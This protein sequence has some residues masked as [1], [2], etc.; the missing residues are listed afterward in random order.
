MCHVQTTYHIWFDVSPESQAEQLPVVHE[1]HYL[2]ITVDNMAEGQV[3]QVLEKEVTCSLCLDLFKDPKKLPCDHVYCKECLRGLALRSLNATISCPE[4]RT[5][6]QIPGNDVINFPTAFRVNRLIEAFQQVQVRVETDSPNTSGICHTH[7][8][9]PLALYCET[10][11]KQVCRDCVLMTKEHADHKYDFFKEVAPKYREKLVSEVSLVKTQDSSISSALGEIIAAE[12]SITNNVQKCQDDVEH[13]FEEMTSILQACKRAMK[14]EATAYYSSLTGVFDQQ[15][16]RLK[17]IQS[18]IKSV[19]T[20]VDTTLRDDDQSFLERMESTFERINN[21]QRKFQTVSLTVAKP[22]LIAMQSTESD[23]DS[24]KQFIKTKYFFG[25]VVDAKMCLVDF[26]NAKLH[27]GQQ[28]SFTLTLR[29]SSGNVC[30]R[31]NEVN[32]DLLPRQGNLI[33]GKLV[34]LSQG[35]VKVILTPERRGQQ[36]LNV[37]VNGAHIKNSPFNVTVYMPPQFFSRPVATISGL[38]RPS[39]LVY[40]QVEDKVLATEMNKERVIKIDSQSHLVLSEF[41]KL[42][43]VNEITQDADLNTFYATT[44][45]DQLHK[46]S[47]NGRI[48]K[49]VGWSGKRKSE[50]YCPNGL[51]VSKSHELYVCDSGNNRVQIFDLNLNFKRSFGKYGTGK[52]QFN[53]PGDVD[54]DS[55]GNIYVAD[56]NNHRIQVFTCTES[57]V[58]TIILGNQRVNT[59]QPITLLMLDE[60]MYVTDSHNHKVW[61]MNTSGEIIA[62]FGSEY[63]YKPEG[64]AVDKAGFVYVTSHA[65]KIVIF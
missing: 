8:T 60:N 17:D 18:K 49:T 41:T 20:S 43:C 42:T 54:F 52:G 46:L 23:A 50:F 62:T 59:F 11:K 29:D 31:E 36:Q 9:Q 63:L 57:H 13:A 33:K 58:H 56:H 26:M 30:V 28:T 48:I 53:F 45:D 40:S 4:C 61:V 65:S 1:G 47:D 19:V 37:K 27:V 35:H 6:I 39:S 32:V 44:S 25:K 15:K 34:P 10:C 2:A 38:N 5:L 64:I 51:R 3:K 7:P 16:E 21:L 14:D 22:Q 24:L 55:S 12:T